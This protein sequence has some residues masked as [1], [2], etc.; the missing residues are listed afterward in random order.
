[1][2]L[3]AGGLSAIALLQKMHLRLRIFCLFACTELT[4]LMHRIGTFANK[5]CNAIKDFGLIASTKPA[6]ACKQTARVQDVQYTVH[7]N[8]LLHSPKAE[9]SDF[10]TATVHSRPRKHSLGCEFDLSMHPT[11]VSL[12]IVCPPTHVSLEEMRRDSPNAEVLW[13]LWSCLH[14]IVACKTPTAFGGHRARDHIC[15][16]AANVSLCASCCL[17]NA[18]YGHPSIYR[19]VQHVEFSSGNGMHHNR[20][21]CSHVLDKCEAWGERLA[22]AKKKL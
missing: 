1:M 4:L 21:S 10:L 6:L 7:H 18:I 11:P 2:R 19:T 12:P 17:K 13:E 22:L 9:N 20:T 14:A 3:R 5:T 15:P 16:L 8:I